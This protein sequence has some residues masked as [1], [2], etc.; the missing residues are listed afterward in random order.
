M[1]S[2]GNDATPGWCHGV[3]TTSVKVARTTSVDRFVYCP[4]ASP[5]VHLC[6]QSTGCDAATTVPKIL[7]R[8]LTKNVR[9]IDESP[10]SYYSVFLEGLAKFPQIHDLSADYMVP[11]S[12]A[13]V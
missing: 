1:S 8:M 11:E 6:P 13:A 4:F 3:H 9:L 7:L 5:A 10:C 12:A 2:E